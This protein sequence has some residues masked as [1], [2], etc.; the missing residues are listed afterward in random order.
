MPDEIRGASIELAWRR[1]QF[2]PHGS[3][4]RLITI[5][6]LDGTG[7]T[8]LARGL[9]HHLSR[10]GLQVVGTRFPT[11]RLR[12]SEFFD[13]VQRQ[14][15]LDL[16]DPLAFE[17]DYMVDRIQHCANFIAPALQAGS[18]VVA[19]RYVLSSLGT[20]L[21][22]L[23]ELGRVATAAAMSEAWFADLCRH[24]V[25]PDL[26]LCLR[27]TPATALARL[28][29]REAEQDRAVDAAQ[30]AGLQQLV[31]GLAR[32][33]DMVVVDADRSA[34][35]VLQACASLADGLRPGEGRRA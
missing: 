21:L 10:G 19:D 28:D 20:L 17:V 34:E 6:G 31:L 32:A 2:G 1:L 4:G 5:D 13:L 22:R 14:G 26:A 23:P 3:P 15:R 29:G 30:Y 33:N 11:D 8:T 7:K 12:R 16:V 35:S 27:A 9:V 18:W 25:R 24:L